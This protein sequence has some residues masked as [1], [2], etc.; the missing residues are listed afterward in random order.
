MS[1]QPRHRTRTVLPPLTFNQTPQLQLGTL[2]Q[3]KISFPDYRI[4]YSSRGVLD[5]YLAALGESELFRQNF[6]SRRLVLSVRPGWLF[7]GKVR[8][9]PSYGEASSVAYARIELHLNPTRFLAHHPLPY[10]DLAAADPE[11]V[12]QRNE[13]V[14]AAVASTT[15]GSED[16]LLTPP[17]SGQARPFSRYTLLYITK[18]TQL[19]DRI[20]LRLQT[21]LA[22]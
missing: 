8:V 6:G 19:F 21:P 12:L 20:F 3:L 16:N 13:D 17:H 15:L 1:L 7:S 22:C 14:A 11:V 2:D 10:D 4:R 5:Q 9:F 18:V